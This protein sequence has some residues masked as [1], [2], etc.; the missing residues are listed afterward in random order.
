M[1]KVACIIPARI[2][3]TRL[4]DK[5]LKLIEGIPLIVWVLRNAEAS[6][7]FD[8]IHVA[9]DD[10][11]I[12]D[13][14]NNAGGHAVMTSPDHTSGTDR[15]F[16]VAKQCDAT[17][18]VNIQGDEPRIPHDLLRTFATELK[19]I[20]DNTL[21]TIVSHATI[22][23]KSNPNVVKAVLDRRRNALYFSRSPIPFERDT[24]APALRHTGIYGFSKKSLERFCSF[25]PGELEQTERLEQL[26][27]LENG[28][29]ISCLV[30]DFE[31][32]GIDTQEELEQ[33][34]TMMA[35]NRYG[36]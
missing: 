27:A 25:P 22:E 11:R 34:R 8:E 15:V 3:S 10:T 26:R 16:E 19:Q 5:P 29:T 21:L 32:I 30:H 14:V 20:D 4:P 13:A 9:T 36:H 6:G 24:V 18:F 12:A 1:T 23:E 35:G 2:G 7:A 33:F 28:M 17:H 31:S